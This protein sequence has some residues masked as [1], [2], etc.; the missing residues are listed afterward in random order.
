MLSQSEA[1]DYAARLIATEQFDWDKIAEGHPSGEILDQTDCD[2][3]KAALETAT[4]MI[5]W[6]DDSR[7]FESTDR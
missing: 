2:Q 1:R 5:F 7:V 6:D 3:V 4:V